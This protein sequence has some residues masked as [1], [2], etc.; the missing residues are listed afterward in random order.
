MKAVWKI[1]S[2]V[3]L[4]IILILLLAVISL[5]GSLIVQ[6]PYDV[7]HNP[8][9]ESYW[10]NHIAQPIFGF[11]TDFLEFIG[12]F[13]IFHSPLFLFI[14]GLL[15]LNILICS[16][17]RLPYLI[18]T[19][20]SIS[21]KRVKQALDRNT[22]GEIYSHLSYIEMSAVVSAYLEKYRYRIRQF[23]NSDSVYLV[24]DKN[25]YTPWGTYLVHF[26]L[27][28]LVAG[29]LAGSYFGF[30]EDSFIVLENSARPVEHG[31]DLSLLLKSFEDE[32]W[33]DGTPKDYRS[34]VAIMSDSRIIKEGTIRVNYPLSING[35]N[36]YQ[37]FFGPAASISVTDV[38][39]ETLF[40]NSIA[41]ANVLQYN[42]APHP[43][44]IL[45]LEDIGLVGY[46]IGVPLGSE[47][48][49]VTSDAL[50]LELYNK[51]DS[52]FVDQVLLY[53]GNTTKVQ[54][55]DIALESLYEFSG[56]KLKYDPG[57]PLIWL[58]CF[59]FLFGITLVFYFPYRQILLMAVADGAGSRVSY[60]SR[61]S[62][63]Q[64]VNKEITD[65]NDLLYAPNE[66]LLNKDRGTTAK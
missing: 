38:D 24:A 26:S 34:E 63:K 32:Y 37:A 55:L 7:A 64:T 12:V 3:R 61:S 39:G 44:G 30:Q 14:G 49:V 58:S 65:I 60:K 54:G 40:N 62:S 22:E 51:D 6:M 19:S 53:V 1:L 50:S 18:N 47:D 4:A 43:Y 59:M 25:R 5:L 20:R 16:L 28:I 35:I 13:D 29:Y 2:S 48:D 33:P 52:S 21:L 17:S 15:M 36:I 23:T 57:I 56:F 45:S 10:L 41:L 8:V 42:G 9:A 46:L 66:S 27:I 31:Y 11:S